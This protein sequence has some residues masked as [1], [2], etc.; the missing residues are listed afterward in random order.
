MAARCG[1]CG[2]VWLPERRELHNAPTVLYT[3]LTFLYAQTVDG[4]E[5]DSDGAE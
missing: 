4:A 2:A 3:G 1:R 5:R